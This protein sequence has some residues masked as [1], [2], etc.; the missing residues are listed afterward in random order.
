[1]KHL[2]IDFI[3]KHYKE[4][5]AALNAFYPA[6]DAAYKAGMPHNAISF[7]G[8]TALAMYH[9]QH[10]STFDIVLFVKS[11]KHLSLLSPKR[12]LDSGS[13]F[14]AKHIDLSHHISVTSNN[15]VVI[16]VLVSE[17]KKDCFIDN[18]RAFF[19]F[20][21][22]VEN[23]ESIIA[24]KIIYRSSDNRT[25]D[26]FDIAVA[27]HKDNMLLKN[28][29]KTQKLDKRHLL[30]LQD[31]I[32]RINLDKYNNEIDKLK[33]FDKYKNVANDAIRFILKKI[34]EATK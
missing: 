15:G 23:M 22:D 29:L 16:D 11:T 28:M 4:Q 34:Y 14:H 27:L 10:R 9:F 19:S 24:K 25:N 7:G 18:T 2:D 32:K 31:A 33:A 26:I 30:A 13:N 21:I 12:W 1:M 5:I 3:R 20:D 6:I 8:S 17:I